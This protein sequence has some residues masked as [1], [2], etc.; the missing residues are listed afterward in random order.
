MQSTWYRSASPCSLAPIRS[1]A[2]PPTPASTSSKTSVRPGR[3]VEI[4]VRSAS[5]T[6]ESS[7]PEA[8]RA[9]GRTSSPGLA[10]K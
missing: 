10:E 9:S 3:S 1:A 4:T 5:M 8:M 6:R 2:S 7:P